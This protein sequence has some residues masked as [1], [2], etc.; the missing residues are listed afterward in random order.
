M[1]MN[2]GIIKSTK[3]QKETQNLTKILQ[4]ITDLSTLQSTRKSSPTMEILEQL[5][6]QG[7][8]SSQGVFCSWAA[9]CP[10]GTHQSVSSG[11]THNLIMLMYSSYILISNIDLLGVSKENM[12]TVSDD[13]KLSLRSNNPLVKL[14]INHLESCLRR[15]E[16]SLIWTLCFTI[17]IR[18]LPNII[19][20]I[21]GWR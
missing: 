17:N 12:S 19:N 7:F 9:A 3:H 13:F 16:T 21:L 18:F 15:R 10:I 1:N 5:F 11:R 4:I 6:S 20:P 8:P 2:D 14:R